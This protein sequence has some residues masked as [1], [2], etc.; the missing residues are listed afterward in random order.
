MNVRTSSRELA[1]SAGTLVLR[2][3]LNFP[4]RV[5][6]PIDRLNASNDDQGR[7]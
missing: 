6:I 5:S 7:S 4:E 1:A 2:Y 3:G